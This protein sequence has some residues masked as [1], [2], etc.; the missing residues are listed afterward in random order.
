MSSDRKSSSELR[1]FDRSLPMTLLKAREAVM[2]KFL[3][4]LREHDLS[5]QQWRVLRALM[6]AP[7][8]DASEIAERCAILLPS[9]SRIL[10]NLERRALVRRKTD[11]KD[12]RRSLVSI[13]PKGVRL[14]EKIA[15]ISEERYQHI[16]QKF[17]EQRLSDLYDMLGQLIECLE[18][19]EGDSS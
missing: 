11:R 7:H 13:T 4:S 10:Q 18:N 12:Q 16:T 9:L 2:R 5:A 17:G 19:D 14:V 6:E 3:P 8:R 1:E 15:P